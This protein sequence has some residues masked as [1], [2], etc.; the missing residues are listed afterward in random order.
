MQNTLGRKTLAGRKESSKIL[1]S[2]QGNEP[3]IFEP[4]EIL[5]Q[6][7]I[8]ESNNLA[9]LEI[10]HTYGNHSLVHKDY[11]QQKRFAEGY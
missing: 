5:G 4:R 2:R 3:R 8:K 9:F 7:P 1:S 10:N 6:R 11:P